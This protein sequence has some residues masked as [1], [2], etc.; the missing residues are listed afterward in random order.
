MHILFSIALTLLFG[1]LLVALFLK[2]HFFQTLINSTAPLSSLS[3][4]TIT[5]H[6]VPT[7]ISLFSTRYLTKLVLSHSNLHHISKKIGYMP[8]LSHLDLS[9][10]ELMT[11][12]R[13][14]SYLEL[15]KYFN[16]ESNQLLSLPCEFE[17]LECLNE[18]H[19]VFPL[20]NQ[21]AFHLR[22]IAS[23]NLFENGR[24]NI[25][26]TPS[27]PTLFL[28]SL[29]SVSSLNNLTEILSELSLDLRVR[30]RNFANCSL[31]HLLVEKA[32]LAKVYLPGS[33]FSRRLCVCV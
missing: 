23:S 30:F 15:L 20:Q 28:L 14:I 29:R 4:D 8:F 13:S 5:V 32:T 3:N 26:F 22:K 24:K 6:N 17:S 10:N 1:T 31:C 18:T 21:N 25:K 2:K 7:I 27:F 16:F 19:C 12:P 33:L 9:F 11:L